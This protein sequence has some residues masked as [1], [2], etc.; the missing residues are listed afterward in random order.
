MPETSI[1]VVIPAYNEQKIILEGL[2]RIEAYCGL[3]KWD[4]EIIVASDGSTDATHRL[5][6]EWIAKR[7]DDRVKL[8]PREDNRGKGDAVRRGV[9]G[10]GGSLILVTDADLS[11]PIKEVDK[12]IR[13]LDSGADIAIGSRAVRSPG[14][15]IRQTFRRRL[16]GRIF[17]FFVQAVILPG[18]QDTQCG[19]KCFKASVGAELFRAQRLNGFS[20]DV[21]ILYL[22]RK[23]GYKIQEVPV[24]WSQGAGSKVSFLRDPLLMLKDIFLLKKIHG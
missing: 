15:D 24:M 6:S 5:V 13:A 23:R 8:F 10:A 16:A 19:F 12:L 7:Q 20:F 22:A 9:L 17:N 18:I 3:K 4:W 21:E 14:C 11:A 2:R 1:S